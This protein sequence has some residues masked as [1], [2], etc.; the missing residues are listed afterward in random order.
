[1]LP[2]SVSFQS[3]AHA[4]RHH[5]MVQAFLQATRSVANGKPKRK[6]DKDTHGPGKKTIIIRR[7]RRD[8]FG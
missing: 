8:A 6:L 4:A 1:M 3:M 7:R 2:P 5:S